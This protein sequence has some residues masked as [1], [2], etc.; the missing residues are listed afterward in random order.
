M[1]QTSPEK[2]Q[3]DG[4]ISVELHGM[5]LD[6]AAAAL[7]PEFSR[8]RLQSWIKR[9]SLTLDG[10]AVRPRDKV[11]IGQSLVLSA[12]SEPEVTWSGQDIPLDIIYED[13]HII[14]LNKQ[15]GIVVHPGA[16][17]SDGTLVNALL[18]FAPEL[19]RLPRGGIV[20]RLDKDTSG[21]MF[22]A[23]STLAHQSLIKQLAER[24]VSREYAAVCIG[25]LS[26][27]G[28]VNE[29]IGRHPTARTRMAVV[30]SGKPAVTHYRLAERFGHHTHAAVHLE[31]GRTHQIRVHMAHRKNPLVGDPQY[32]GRTR[33]PPA[34]S[35]ELIAGLRGFPRQA[36]HARTLA[37]EHPASEERVAFETRL[38]E[39]LNA[40][41][42]LLRREDPPL[43]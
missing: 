4:T 7:F 9:G 5:R 15:A 22:V 3:R 19:D 35:D 1:T 34:A 21:I 39:D 10:A 38:P 13:E 25:A 11:A 28:T 14:V 12:D 40:L 8:A 17:N 33:I 18:G 6:Q 16:G 32:G 30:R 26:G 29:P 42:Q 24:T 43:A 41:L 20:H 2:I 37:F 36:L 23:R 27:G 31:T